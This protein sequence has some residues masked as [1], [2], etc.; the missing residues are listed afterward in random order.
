MQKK[1]LLE[2]ITKTPII[3]AACQKVGIG[4]TTF[5]RWQR[6]D[7]AFATACESA[8]GIGVELVNDLAVSKLMTLIQDGN[9][10][11][12]HFWLKNRHKAFGDKLRIET[13]LDSKKSQ[14]SS[15]E[16]TL[17]AQIISE[18]AD[19]RNSLINQTPYGTQPAIT[20]EDTDAEPAQPSL[21]GGG[22]VARPDEPVVP[23]ATDEELP[24]DLCEGIL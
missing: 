3:E 9:M 11:A 21:D 10:Q 18:L 17:A 14:L 16:F 15:E 5:Y 23:D 19:R 1:L 4:R 12:I 7:E 13:P 6:E 2:Q 20:T 24:R 8:L 22:D